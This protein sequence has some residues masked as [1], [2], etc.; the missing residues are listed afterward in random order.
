MSPFRNVAG[1]VLQL[2]EDLQKMPITNKIAFRRL[3]MEKC[4]AVKETVTEFQGY[5][6]ERE[7][8]CSF[9]DINIELAD[10]PE[11]G[12]DDDENDE[13]DE[14]DERD[15]T[16]EEAKV[17]QKCVQVM[18]IAQE[19][20][21][22]SLS[23]VT[24]IGDAVLTGTDTSVYPACFGHLAR[25]IQAVEVIETDITELGIEL[26]PPVEIIDLS[27]DSIPNSS[28]LSKAYYQAMQSVRKLYS[29][30]RNPQWSSHLSA[31]L[32]E[33]LT[34]IDSMVTLL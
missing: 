32:Q 6:D 8:N 13:G 20:M 12:G 3:I 29:L 28:P 16:E 33:K 10:E 22:L 11:N 4:L 26:Y 34:G 15:Y 31:E 30:L 27:Q 25:I 21:K 18:M 19:L 1:M 23:V 17:V 7:A 24:S 5:L 14:E 2:S 9:K